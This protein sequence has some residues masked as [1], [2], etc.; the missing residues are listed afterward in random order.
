MM[1]RQGGAGR[2][3]LVPSG[4]RTTLRPRA[5]AAPRAEAWWSRSLVAAAAPRGEAG[6]RR[7]QYGYGHVWSVPGSTRTRAPPREDVA[8]GCWRDGPAKAGAP[9]SLRRG[10]RRYCARD[11]RGIVSMTQTRWLPHGQQ[12]PTCP[13]GA[14]DNRSLD[15]PLVPLLSRLRGQQA[16]KALDL[17]ARPEAGKSY[18]SHPRPRTIARRARAS[19]RG[20]V[21]PLHPAVRQRTCACG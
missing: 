15:Y 7:G 20:M 19:V 5:S 10:G 13:A 11:H 14:V 16:G 6:W 3:A 21:R 17:P 4:R 9:Y 12:C 2:A 8:R 18:G 1:A